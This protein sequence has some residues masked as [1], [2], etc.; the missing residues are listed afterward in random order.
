MRQPDA[1]AIAVI[2]PTLDP[3]RWLGP[4]LASLAAQRRSDFRVVV[5]DN[6]ADGAAERVAVPPGLDVA[7]IGAGENRGFAAAVDDA[8]RATRTPY[9]A[10][11][12]DDARPEPS[13]LATLAGVLDAEPTVAIV[14][15]TIVADADP[16][17]LDNAGDGLGRW[18]LP[19][20]IGRF[21]TDRGQYATRDVLSASW[22]AVVMRR[23]AYDA[24]GGLERSLFAYF[25]DVDF[26]LRAHRAGLRARFVAEARCRH[27]GSA[28]TGSMI[29]ATTVRLST[30]NLVRVQA[31]NLP[32]AVVWPRVHRLLAGHAYWFAKMALKE[33]H[34]IA[35]LRGFLAGLTR[36]PSD[37][38]WHRMRAGD[39]AVDAAAVRAAFDRSAAEV[40]ASIRAKRARD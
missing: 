22:C 14:A 28:T 21:E 16:T 40:A 26:G 37:R 24:V 2:V 25:E 39:A 31:R 18:F 10:V 7:V 9:V 19:Y 30:R 33:R 11:L 17:R 38:R 34:P 32:A 13:W 20:P 5:A 29:N 36:V 12:N 15:P 23:A 8:I 6:S 4:C 1:H 35:W 27:V 3:V